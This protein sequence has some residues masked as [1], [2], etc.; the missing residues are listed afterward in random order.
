[1]SD[2]N[3]PVATGEDDGI[4]VNVMLGLANRELVFLHD[5]FAARGEISE[6]ASGAEFLETLEIA[7]LALHRLRSERSGSHEPASGDDRAVQDAIS[8]MKREQS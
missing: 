8:A 3:P 6:T 4:D 2:A 1:M 5:H 7:R